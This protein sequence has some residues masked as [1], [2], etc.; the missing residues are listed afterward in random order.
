M[1]FAIAFAHQVDRVVHPDKEYTIYTY[2]IDGI[3]NGKY[4]INVPYYHTII[5]NDKKT[6][7]VAVYNSSFTLHSDD[8][9]KVDVFHEGRQVDSFDATK[10]DIDAGLVIRKN[11]GYL[12][13]NSTK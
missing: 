8:N 11:S 5:Q 2:D 1:M 7:M 13:I 9:G 6:T 12:R 10:K 4:V 3:I